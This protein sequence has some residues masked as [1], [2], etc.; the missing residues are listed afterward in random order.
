MKEESIL[1]ATAP[2]SFRYLQR[3]S[4]ESSLIS[5]PILSLIIS[6]RII[7]KDEIIPHSM[8]CFQRKERVMKRWNGQSQGISLGL[9][10]R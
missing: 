5:L 2:V 10:D 7:F 6:S 1:M 9:S 3:S 8:T 4:L